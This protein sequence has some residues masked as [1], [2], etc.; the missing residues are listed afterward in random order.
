MQYAKSLIGRQLKSIAQTAV[1]HLH[2]LVPPNIYRLWKAIGTLSTMLWF[3]E[4]DD[5]E[6]YLVCTGILRFS[7]L[8][9]TASF[10]GYTEG[11][12]NMCRQRIGCVYTDRPNENHS[13]GQVACTNTYHRGHSSVRP[14][15]R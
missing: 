1:F 7:T 2:D 12:A 10:I 9:E 3:P 5:I 4:L 6:L 8:I 15:T 13:E 11:R 14:F